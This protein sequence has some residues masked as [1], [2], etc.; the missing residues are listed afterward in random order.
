MSSKSTSWSSQTIDSKD[1]GRRCAGIGSISASSENSMSDAAVEE[2]AVCAAKEEDVPRTS[3]RSTVLNAGA[4]HSR[5][6]TMTSV[7]IPRKLCFLLRPRNL[8]RI[9]HMTTGSFI[10]GIAT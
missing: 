3:R 2:V 6:P 1:G 4:S 5:N 7:P 10:P 8:P 9:M